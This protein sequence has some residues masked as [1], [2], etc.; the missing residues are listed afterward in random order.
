MKANQ[1]KVFRIK[2]TNYYVGKEPEIGSKL[3]AI[4]GKVLEQ[5]ITLTEDILEEVDELPLP[6]LPPE[7]EDIEEE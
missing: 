6:P 7:E 2:G 3:I 4:Y 5:P 1:G